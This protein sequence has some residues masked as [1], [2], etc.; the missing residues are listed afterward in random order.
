MNMLNPLVPG[1]QACVTF[2]WAPGTNGFRKFWPVFP[3]HT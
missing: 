2:Y 3:F 1:V